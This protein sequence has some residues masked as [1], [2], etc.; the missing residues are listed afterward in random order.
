MAVIQDK[1]VL[2]G[3]PRQELEDFVGAKSML[4]ALADCN[5]CIWTLEFLPIVLLAQSVYCPCQNTEKEQ[6]NNT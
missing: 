3:N 1:H 4:H 2:V 6:K 5:Q